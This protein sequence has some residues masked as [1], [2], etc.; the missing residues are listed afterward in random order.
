MKDN[1]TLWIVVILI[2]VH[3]VIGIGWLFYKI[4]GAKP[5]EKPKSEEKE[6]PA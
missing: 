2:A 5:L 6:D 1:T 3:F 4:L